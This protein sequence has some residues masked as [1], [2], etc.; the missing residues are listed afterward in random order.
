MKLFKIFFL[1]VIFYFY[2]RAQNLDFKLDF[3]RFY[4]TKEYANLEIYYSIPRKL[5]KFVRK[6]SLYYAYYRIDIN[7]SKKDS[8][9]LQDSI[10]QKTYVRDTASIKSTQRL[11]D[12]ARYYMKP[13]DYKISFKILDLEALNFAK[14][15][16]R[17]KIDSISNNFT[18]SDIELASIIKNNE[19][20]KFFKNGLMVVP[21]PSKIYGKNLSVLY[22]YVELYNLRT[23]K[24]SAYRSVCKIIDKNNK[25]VKIIKDKNVSIRSNSGLEIYGF[26]IGKFKTGLY[27]LQLEF[28]SLD[29]KIS[30]KKDKYFYIYNPDY[31]YSDEYVEKDSSTLFDLMPEDSINKE[32]EYISVLLS[33]KEKEIIKKLDLKGKRNFL[34][35]F[36]SIMNSKG[37]SRD[38]FYKRIKFANMRFG[39]DKKNKGWNTDR[40]KIY[41]KYGEPD[42]IEKFDKTSGKKAYEIWHY[43]SV[44]GGVSFYFVDMD[45]F[46]NYKLVHSTDPNEF[47]DYNWEKW[48]E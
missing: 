1:L 44:H 38:V 5:L 4:S 20:N 6:D 43:Y 26:K 31:S 9:I 42:N 33:E 29:S 23:L 40:G 45:G 28:Y 7:I 24:D 22:Y 47:H 34:E 10:F 32:T 39:I 13:G 25:L 46:K 41:L 17:V 11:I 36:W 35:N 30:V 19:K 27:K 12:I 48:L 8:L 37:L 21:N 16:M 14:K 3:A 2:S 18:V 15:E